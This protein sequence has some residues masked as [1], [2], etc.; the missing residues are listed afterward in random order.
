M[1]RPSLRTRWRLLVAAVKAVDDT[2]REVSAKIP[3]FWHTNHS[4][5]RMDVTMPPEPGGGR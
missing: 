4:L 3:S 2:L 5:R 1:R